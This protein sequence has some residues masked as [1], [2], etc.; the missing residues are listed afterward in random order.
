LAAYDAAHIVVAHTVQKVA[1]IRSR[2]RG[3][4]FLI[5]TGMLSAYW[6]GGRASALEI[7]AGKFSALYLDSQ[8]V[9]FDAKASS[10][11]EAN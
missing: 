9:L 2:F 4:A 5:D 7:S 6:P 11:G 3:R 8:E 10:S 1:H